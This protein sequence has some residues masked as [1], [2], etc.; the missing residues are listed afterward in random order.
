MAKIKFAV[1]PDAFDQ[2]GFAEQPKP[3]VYEAKIV[4][5]NAGY[6]KDDAGQ[7]DKSRPRLEVIYEITDPKA[8]TKGNDGGSALGARVWDYVTFGKGSQWK[9]AQFT[10]AFGLADKGKPSGEFDTAKLAEKVTDIDKN[11]KK[12]TK[13]TGHP[14]AKCKLRTGPGSDLDGGFKAKVRSILPIGGDG[15]SADTSVV[16]E[17][18]VDD[19]AVA[20]DS[21]EGYSEADL[22]ALSVPELKEVV[23]SFV[24]AGYELDIKGKKK[25]EVIEMILAAQASVGDG[26]VDDEELIDDDEEEMVDDEEET[27]GY[28]EDDLKAMSTDDLKEA[29]KTLNVVIKGKKK[30]EVIAAI[31]EAQTD[32]GGADEAPS[33]GDDDDLPF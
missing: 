26:E 17:E 23:K 4:E 28:S 6:S 16:E 32:S 10:K 27:S 8:K 31:L 11:G 21:A 15:D 25:S 13:E 19:E 22:K 5:I 33:D 30:S 29:A 12:V 1:D 24:E 20:E 9:L 18:M 14:G 3:D 2:T 7:E